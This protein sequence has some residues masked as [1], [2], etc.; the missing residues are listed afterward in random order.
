VQGGADAVIKA[1]AQHAVVSLT[2]H[3]PSLDDIFL[4]YY[5]ADGQA[6]PEVSRVG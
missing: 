1:A 4:R 6:Q 5:Q 3:E 2:S